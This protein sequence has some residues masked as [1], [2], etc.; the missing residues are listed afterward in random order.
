LLTHQQGS[1]ANSEQ[2]RTNPGLSICKAVD[3]MPQ[4][5]PFKNGQQSQAGSPNPGGVLN[6]LGNRTL[7]RLALSICRVSCWL[8]P[9]IIDNTG[10]PSSAW[11]IAFVVEASKE[12]FNVVTS[13]W[14]R[15]FGCS[16]LPPLTLGRPLEA[17][18]KIYFH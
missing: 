12:R 9:W 2:T 8:Q 11:F 15:L 6:P 14:Q 13:L 4:S 3:F 1:T 5:T 17:R 7:E 16:N 18:K 10:R